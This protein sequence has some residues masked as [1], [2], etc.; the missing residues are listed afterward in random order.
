M[1]WPRSRPSSAPLAALVLALSAAPLVAEELPLAV[2]ATGGNV[3]PP[4]PAG[5]TVVVPPRLR[6]PPPGREPPP[7]ADGTT[8][9]PGGR[10]PPPGID[11]DGNRIPPDGREPPPGPPAGASRGEGPPQNPEPPRRVPA[12]GGSLLDS[13]LPAP[14]VVP[15]PRSGGGDELEPGEVVIVSPDLEAARALAAALAA[16]GYRVKRRRRLADLGMVVSVFRLPE[17]VPVGEALRTLRAQ[18]P[19]AWIDGNHRYRLQ[20]EAGARRYGRR[21]TGWEGRPAACGAGL[22]LGLVDTALDLSH[23][24]LAGQAI[25]TRDFLSAGERPAGAEHGTA[26][27]AL[28]VG[29]GRATE[30]G[31]LLPAARLHAAAVFRQRGRRQVDTTAERV[32]HALDWLA[33]E[34]VAVINLSLGGPRNLVVEVAVERLLA[35]GIA[36]V[37]A[38][39]NGGPRAAPVYPA[40]QEGVIAVTAVDA[41]LR[42][43]RRA[44]RGDYID[45]AAPG[46]DLWVARPGGGGKYVSGSSFATPFASAALALAKPPAPGLR[47]RLAAL[48]ATARDLGEPGRDPVFGW[49]L[50]QAGGCGKSGT[51]SPLVQTNASP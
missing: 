48:R 24:A 43:W 1:W 30:F 17:G 10:Q 11:A 32:V 41:R 23:P 12:S 25:V 35:R 46:V 27:A 31:G 50:V 16:E 45:F 15:V 21:L 5:G 20:G 7:P 6:L 36:L 51:L 28:L 39:G 22:R 49:G 26:V 37:A 29:S 47:Q 2:P 40:A 34:G 18:R 19:G 42:P 13:A 8:S 33:R 44:S 4:P 38:A 3:A 9:P 14:P